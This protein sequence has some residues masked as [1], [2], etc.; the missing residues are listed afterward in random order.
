MTAIAAAE[1]TPL[2]AF[3]LPAV[4]QSA[5]AARGHVR[6]ALNRHALAGYCEDAALIASELV[7]NAVT[8]AGGA[9]V[10]VE[11]TCLPGGAVAVIVTDASPRLPVKCDTAEFAEHGRGLWL[12]EALS[13]RWGCTAH[14]RGKSVYAILSRP[15]QTG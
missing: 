8:H 1:S 10:G 13:A 6:A 5:Q 9:T 11:L 4:P 14:S 7:T 15:A 3:T 12:V 2:A